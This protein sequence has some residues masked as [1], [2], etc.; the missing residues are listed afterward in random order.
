MLPTVATWRDHLEMAADD[1]F[2]PIFNTLPAEL[3][4]D[5]HELDDKYVIEVSIPGI[6]PK[7]VKVEYANRVLTIEAKREQRSKESRG[8]TIRNELWKGTASRKFYLNGVNSEEISAKFSNGLLVIDV[9]KSAPDK[10]TIK[11][12]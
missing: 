5:I 9:P 11:I 2:G 3:A 4:S 10:R 1:F 12:V 6:D 7:D 8:S